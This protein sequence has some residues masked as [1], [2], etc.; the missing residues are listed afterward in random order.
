MKICAGIIFL[1]ASLL[2]ESAVA[3]QALQGSRHPDH[4]KDRNPVGQSEFL[5]AQTEG[6]EQA[7][8][9]TVV[10]RTILEDA[11]KLDKDSSDDDK[12]DDND[13][14]SDKKQEQREKLAL[15]NGDAIRFK[16]EKVMMA[17][18]GRISKAEVA[19]D[20]EDDETKVEDQ[21][22]DKSAADEKDEA[23]DKEEGKAEDKE[24]EGKAKDKE[25]KAKKAEDKSEDDEKD[26]AED[27][28]EGKAEDK[29][30]EGKV[31]SKEEKDKSTKPEKE[32]KAEATEIELEQKM[33]ERKGI[34]RAIES[35]N[36]KVAFEAEVNSDVKLIG[37]E[38][39]SPKLASFLGNMWKEM[40]KFASPF[41]KEFLGQQLKDA[42]AEIAKLEKKV[43]AEDEKETK[44]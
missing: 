19:K 1:V 8:E 33:E 11:T 31:E 21:T 16:A 14:V 42:D 24:E 37:E 23:E 10:Y 43:E 39:K 17:A 44:D 34:Q 22:E 28:E 32:E 41:F 36:D 3:V 40:R 27:K 35:F 7:A 38:A 4:S 29:E 5:Q 9:D 26:E 13:D 15:L 25:E 18:E 12:D 30:E 20:K 6:S 2:Q